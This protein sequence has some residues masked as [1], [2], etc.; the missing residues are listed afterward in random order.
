MEWHK[1]AENLNY[2]CTIDKCGSNFHFPLIE[3]ILLIIANI[4]NETVFMNIAD[5]FY[6]TCRN[7]I[8]V[9]LFLW[10][11]SNSKL[12]N[13]YTSILLCSWM[14]EKVKMWRIWVEIA[15]KEVKIDKW[16]WCQFYYEQFLVDSIFVYL[17]S[18]KYRQI[19]G[20]FLEYEI[21][22]ISRQIF[23]IPELKKASRILLHIPQ[24]PVDFLYCLR[25]ISLSRC[26]A[27]YPIYALAF[28]HS[29]EYLPCI[30]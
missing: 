6:R 8:L 4:P 14:S 19:L 12:F 5:N 30:L 23:R 17:T 10:I 28:C 27:L 11:I 16:V 13:K 21:F 1:R 18:K 9:S 2:A 22:G 15:N 25:F 26:Q 29:P 7:V 24:C 3:V 20:T